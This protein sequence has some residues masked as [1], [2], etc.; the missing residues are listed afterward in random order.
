MTKEVEEYKARRR[1]E[2]EAEAKQKLAL[3]KIIL[4]AIKVKVT[5]SLSTGPKP[6]KA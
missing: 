2:A 3:R 4:P 1:A 5:G 6:P